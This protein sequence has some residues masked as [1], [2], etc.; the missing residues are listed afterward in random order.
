MRSTGLGENRMGGHAPKPCSLF[1]E[2]ES[3]CQLDK[4]RAVPSLPD[5][6]VPFIRGVRMVSK[7]V[8]GYRD[9]R[10]KRFAKKR[11]A[12]THEFLN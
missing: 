6:G 2:P 10:M 4:I 12:L 7:N 5:A 3:I 9:V 1:K 11:T 8:F